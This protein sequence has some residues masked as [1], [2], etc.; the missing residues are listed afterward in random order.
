[1]KHDEQELK[2]A[3]ILYE[4]HTEPPEEI[5]GKHLCDPEVEILPGIIYSTE[6]GSKVRINW[7]HEGFAGVEIIERGKY[8]NRGDY[9]WAW[10]IQKV[11]EE[12]REATKILETPQTPKLKPFE[13]LPEIEQHFWLESA[14]EVLEN[15]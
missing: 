15:L 2:V 7:V 10:Y 14:R 6:K 4:R 3:K 9:P 12:N 8:E 1:M 11:K 5:V 13:D